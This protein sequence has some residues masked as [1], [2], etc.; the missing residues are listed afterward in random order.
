[1]ERFAFFWVF[2]PVVWIMQARML[3]LLKR[4]IER[5][6]KAPPQPESASSH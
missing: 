4:N 5:A 2:P 1:M 3:A 6:A